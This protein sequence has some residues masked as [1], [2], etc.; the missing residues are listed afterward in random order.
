M[1]IERL[2]FSW[3]TRT[4]RVHKVAWK[5]V[6]Q[7]T[8]LFGDEVDQLLCIKCSSLLLTPPPHEFQSF[9]KATE[10]MRKTTK[11][12][13]Q[14]ESLGF[15]I[16]AKAN[17]ETNKR[18]KIWTT[19]FC[20]TERLAVTI[21]ITT[22]KFVICD[23]LIPMFVRITKIKRRQFQNRFGHRSIMVIGVRISI[24]IT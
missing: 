15:F 11:D 22:I 6:S 2:Q 19:S 24:S 5:K 23:Y 1:I 4:C 9:C 14:L 18:I 20:N 3:Q 7:V 8:T 12:Y 16:E 13:L 21:C 17:N 10:V